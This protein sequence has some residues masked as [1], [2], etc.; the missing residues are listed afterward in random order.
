MDDRI[1]KATLQEIENHAVEIAGGAGRILAGHFGRSLKIDYKDDAER[2][3]VTEADHETQAY[4]VD[5]I[6]ARFPDHGILGEEDDEET[7]DDK[8][9]A[10]DFLWVLDPLDGTKNFL[11]GLPVYASSIGVL[12]KGAPVAGAVFVPWPGAANGGLVFHARKG[13]G[14]F[15]DGQ[16]ISVLDSDGPKGN[17]LV[18]LPAG[19]GSFLGFRK[20][21]IGKVGELRVTGSIAYELVMVARGV[22][23]YMVTTA[24]HLWDVA[25]GV[26][27]VMEAG[28]IL[29]RG[30]RDPGPLGLFPSTRWEE[31]ETLVPDWRSGQ[32]SLGDVRR[33]R[34][35]LTLGSP[36]VA[37]FVTANMRRRSN[38]RRR[39]VR[40]IR[41]LRPRRRK[42]GA[43][44]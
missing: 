20:P 37:R 15:A 1:N 14:A 23:Q 21:M 12:F 43:Q 10:P 33:W 19:F 32:T 5:A 40:R 27:L 7:R 24:P 28:G 31:V 13:G 42:D 35:P 44:G 41:S 11:H 30:S 22:T 3:P 18:T 2:D 25:G 4:L 6:K 9:A 8:S 16:P 34:A 26:A 17:V 36:G 29:M 38:L 39:L